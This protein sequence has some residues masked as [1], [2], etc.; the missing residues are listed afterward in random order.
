M[1]AI[2]G[3][4]T[5]SS[6][7]PDWPPTV[8]ATSLPMTWAATWQTDSGMTGLTLPGMI[9]EPGCSAGSVISRQAAARPDDSR[10]RSLAIFIRS[11]ASVLR[12]PLAATTA[13]RLPSPSKR[14]ADGAQ[15]QA[16]PL[17][18]RGEGAGGE[19]GVGVDAGADR[20]AAERDFLQHR[21]RLA[22]PVE[23]V[24]HHAGVA[25]EF[26]A[27]ADRRG[28]L[29]V[30]AADLDHVVELARLGGQGVAQLGQRRQQLPVEGEQG[31]EVDGGRE[32]VVARLAAVDVVVGMDRLLGGAAAGEDFVGPPGDDLVGVHVAGRA[33]AGLEHVHD[34]LVV[35]AAVG[36]L[37]GSAGDGVGHGA[38][39]AARAPALARAAA[40]LSRPSAR[41]NP[42]RS[43]RPL[44]GKL[45][46]ARAVW[47]P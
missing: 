18:D 47:A 33:R 14:S 25:A 21:P 35:E 29:K 27:E 2:I 16:G 12:A 36:D 30:G 26:L 28:V 7:S 4:I 43:P 1:S 39:A 38:R 45:S 22:Q 9:D 20:R 11:A 31:G 34:E 24:L 46:R 10:R 37:V 42:G 15:G 32:D 6:S 44:T 23:A 41:I 3:I 5:F 19:L 13:W 17:V 40:A 8:I